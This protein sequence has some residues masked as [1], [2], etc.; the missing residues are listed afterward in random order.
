M[1][2]NLRASEANIDPAPARPSSRWNWLII[3][4]I[5]T[6]PA[7]FS[8]VLTHTRLTQLGRETVFWKWLLDYSL[9]WYIWAALTPVVLWLGRRFRFEKGRI[10]TA[11]AAHLP[12]A[13]ALSVFQIALAVFFSIVVYAEPL[14]WDYFA[15]QVTP[16]IFGR[17][18]S[19]TTVYF[20][21]LGVGYALEY[22]RRFS[23]RAL[24]AAQL[25]SQ[26][27]QARLEVLQQQLQ[28]HFLFNTL[29]SISVL[30]Q[31]GEN[32]AATA[33][34]GYLS[35]LL[36][37]SLGKDRPQLVSLADELE[38]VY[39]YVEIE[40]V[41]Y[42]DRLR[43]EFDIAEALKGQMIPGFALQILVENAIRHGVASKAL[44]GRV[45]VFGEIADTRLRLCVSDDG[46]GL[47]DAPREGIG[48]ANIR[49][50]LQHLYGVDQLF[51]VENSP[52]GG[53]TA[54]I[55]IPLDAAAGAS[56]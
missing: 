23:E 32:A 45:R 52:S 29:N 21:I 40:R 16:T 46:A 12:V 39:R 47:G 33:M 17:L 42:G 6:V 54:T 15:G 3:I 13:V 43:V 14:N 28:P 8:A 31:K 7:V 49:T 26:L 25:A 37:S 1:P 51:R 10:L 30:I 11:V 35:D 18:P 27:N 20:V 36:R 19:Q 24:A 34:L 22:Q 55:E 48:L 2:Q 41:R 56:K 44:A 9:A 50:R 53:V 5:F 4:A 38:F